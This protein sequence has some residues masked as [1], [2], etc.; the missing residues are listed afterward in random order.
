MSVSKDT[1]KGISFKFVHEKCLILKISK[2]ITI[3]RKFDNLY[4]PC[5]KSDSEHHHTVNLSE[6]SRNKLWHKRFGHLRNI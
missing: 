6:T 4:Y 5:T 3:G 2:V 1:N